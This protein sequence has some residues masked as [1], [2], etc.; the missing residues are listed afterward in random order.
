[1][2]TP[3]S[4]I[5]VTPLKSDRKHGLL[6]IKILSSYLLSGN[7]DRYYFNEILFNSVI[8]SLA[9]VSKENRFAK[10]QTQYSSVNTLPR[11]VIITLKVRKMTFSNTS[12]VTIQKYTFTFCNLMKK[13]NLYEIC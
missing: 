7:N 9:L 8:S 13:N 1:M 3:I 12:I 4:S 10:F 5:N 11:F 2:H 6:S